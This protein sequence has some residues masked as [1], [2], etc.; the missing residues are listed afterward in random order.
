MVRGDVLQIV[1]FSVLFALAVSAVGDKGKRSCARWKASPGHVQVHNY[2]MM[3]APVG[4]GA[5]MATPSAPRARC[6][7]N[8]GN[9]ILSCISPSSF[10]LSRFGAV[11]AI[12]R[13][14]SANS[15][16]PCANRRARLCY[17]FERIR[18]TESDASHGTLRRPRHIVGFVMPTG[19]S[20]NLDGSTLYLAWQRLRRPGRRNHD[21]FP[22]GFSAQPHHDPYSDANS[23]GV[24]AVRAPP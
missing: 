11:I 9:L 21:G 19:Y 12:V 16:G 7:L 23:K 13:I 24:A 18:V 20:F 10:S 4:V 2:V 17:Y 6:S 8:L 22:H 14:R 1:A 3:F 15:S 5:A